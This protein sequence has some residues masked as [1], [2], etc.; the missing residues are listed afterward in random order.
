MKTGVILEV[1]VATMIVLISH[2]DSALLST[3]V[4]LQWPETTG[5][6]SVTYTDRL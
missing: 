5:Y 3:T 1:S 4:R 2:S 6:N